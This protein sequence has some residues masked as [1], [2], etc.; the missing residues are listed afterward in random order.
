MTHDDVLAALP[1]ETRAAL[2]A[3]S[4]TA[5]LTHLAGHL[6]LLAATRTW[7]AT[8]SPLWWAVLPLHGVVLVFLFTLEHECTHRTPFATPRLNEVVGHAAGVLL[9]LQFQWFRYFH[10]AH[11]RHTNDPEN[12]P[13]LL[14]GGKPET[15]RAYAL[16]VS[17]LPVWIANL[18]V[19]AGNT[20]GAAPAGYVP[21]RALP[22]IRR[23]ARLMVAG[24]LCALLIAPGPAFWLWL[25]PMVLGQP[26]L[27][28]YLLAEHSRCPHV[29][30]MLENTRTTFTTR[31]VRF[32]AWNMPY[33][34]EHH[35]APNVPFHRL[36]DLHE[37]MKAHLV[38]TAAGYVAFTRD[39]VS[40]LEG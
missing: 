31:T 7:I 35:S 32:L 12:D 18:R 16:H 24:Y 36:P 29:A 40:S 10:L 14:G 8:A 28:L 4:D 9:I 26:A 19:L 15:W 27:R 23:E 22:R 39:Y 1:P 30:N 5:G 37:E 34:I 17:G 2:H 13:E 6:G 3:P 25:L 20:T 21:A 38:T 11:H 33:H